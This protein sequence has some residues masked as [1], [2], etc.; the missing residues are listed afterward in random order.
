[1]NWKK[2]EDGVICSG[3]Y[4]GLCNGVLAFTNTNLLKSNHFMENG[5]KLTNESTEPLVSNSAIEDIFDVVN[6]VFI[7]LMKL[8]EK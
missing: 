5:I 3:A 2:V 4:I 7:H 6:L 1:M 8:A